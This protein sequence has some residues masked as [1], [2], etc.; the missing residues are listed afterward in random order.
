V[1][2]SDS[3]ILSL[4]AV[5]RYT[6]WLLV[7]LLLVTPACERSKTA[8]HGRTAEAYVP[9]SGSVGFDITSFESVNGS[10][11]LTAVYTS[12]GRTAKFGVEFGTAKI[13]DAKDP[14]DFPMKVGEGRFVSAPGSDASVLLLDLKKALEAKALPSKARRLERLPFTFVNIGENL[15]QAANG[16]FNAE[17]P[18]N[19]TAIKIFIGE[20]EQE[21][22]L[23]LNINEVSRKGQFSIKDPDYGD[24]ALAQLGEVL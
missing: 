9:D 11:R 22:Q 7:T 4:S 17:P 16:G 8:P 2:R 19:W 6:V 20:G 12:Q 1:S 15:S 24:L 3:G 13:I 23:F 14:K 5:Q 21:A 10:L 18:G